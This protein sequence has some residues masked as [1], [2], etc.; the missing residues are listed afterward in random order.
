MFNTFV[1]N[2]ICKLRG[3]SWSKHLFRRTIFEKHQVPFK[4]RNYALTPPWHV[5]T[6]LL[7]QFSQWVTLT[8]VKDDTGMIQGSSR[9]LGTTIPLAY[10]PKE[11]WFLGG[12]VWA[13]WEENCRP[14]KSWNF[15]FKTTLLSSNTVFI[16]AIKTCDP[17]CAT[18]PGAKEI[19]VSIP[20]N[21]G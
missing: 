12:T 6:P 1:T 16:F 7:I 8:L 18:Q 15:W 13:F 9:I 20:Q 2:V 17:I 10:L 4:D 19:N 21:S 3:W 11:S 5:A 14:N